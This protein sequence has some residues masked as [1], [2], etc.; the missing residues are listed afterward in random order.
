MAVMLL[1]FVL[2]LMKS[3]EGLSGAE[4]KTLCSSNSCFTLHME[5]VSFEEASERCYHNG[6]YLMSIRE[7]REEDLLLELLSQMKNQRQNRSVQFWIGLKL[8]RGD[9]VLAHKTL[10]GFKWVSGEE[11][12]HY[13]NWGRDPTSTCTTERCVSVRY[14][15]LGQTQLK[16]ADGSCTAHAFY[17]CR[18]YFRG[19]CKPLA[20]LGPGQVT[21]TAPFSEEKQRNEMQLF[22]LGTY[23]ET[24]CGDNKS[25]FSVC[26]ETDNFFHWTDPGP[27]CKMEKRNCTINNGE[28]E[29]LCFQD[30]DEAQCICKEGYNLNEDGLTCRMNDMCGLDTCDHQCVIGESG[31]SCKCPDGFKLDENQHN[32][33][34]IDECQS[35]ICG[36]H[37]CINTHGSYSCVCRDG[38]EMVEGKCNDIDECVQSRCEHL[39]SNTIGSFFCKC[40][41]GFTLSE[42]GYSC[43]DINECISSLCHHQCVN[44][45]GSFLCTCKQGFKMET[46]GTT[47]VPDMTIT[48]AAS[49]DD[50]AKAETQ[51]NLTEF[52]T[53]HSNE[54][55]SPYTPL[56]ESVN[57]TYSD[58]QNNNISSLTSLAK[59]VNS[60]VI[61][62]VLGSVIPL[63]ILVTVAAAIAIFRC[64]QS[65]KKAKKKATTDG[66]CWV[67]S[68]LD[69]RLEKL[70]ESILT[71]DL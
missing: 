67:S 68:G 34:D 43:V 18:F 21:Y 25:H 69:P 52:L 29:H 70:Y 7:K 40:N 33:S 27:F 64:S 22:P 48:A 12:S 61:I 2:Q 38:Y 24:V 62:C 9:C 13:S 19:M 53:R 39:C 14:T 36:I 71:D 63:L 1:V 56:S 65:Q 17:V 66:Y 8:H 50:Q 4:H 10:K 55:Q 47:C 31:Y 6:G 20:L 15:S 26:R 57:V 60:R 46:N 3:F 59:T 49:P 5:K 35:Q 58:Q 51:E 28:C 23:A 37:L 32:C 45:E 42:D 44:T 16:W 11:D 54:L 30:A 41:E